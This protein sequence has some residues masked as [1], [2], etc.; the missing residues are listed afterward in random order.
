M[1][2][3]NNTNDVLKNEAFERD[4]LPQGLNILTILTIVWCSISGIITLLMPWFMKF[5]MNIM[6]KAA[7]GKDL[8]AKKLE[9]MEKSRHAFEILQANLIPTLI[10]GIIGVALCFVGA[11][12]MRK[13]KKDGFWIYVAGQVLPIIGSLALLGTS[14]FTGVTSYVFAAIPFLFIYLYS[15]QLKYLTK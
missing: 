2:D 13:F 1:T 4:T 9:E 8:S 12:M 5:M 3:Y 11:I 6:D 7:E 10:I 14:Q 15:R